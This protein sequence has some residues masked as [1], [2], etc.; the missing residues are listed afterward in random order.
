MRVRGLNVLVSLVTLMLTASEVSIELSPCEYLGIHVPVILR[1]LPLLAASV[2]FACSSFLG[3]PGRNGTSRTRALLGVV[4][5]LLTVISAIT[6]SSLTVAAYRS[7][8]IAVLR[9]RR[10]TLTMQQL[11]ATEEELGF[12]LMLQSADNHDLLLFERGTGRAAE[13][14]RKLG[15]LGIACV[16]A[17]DSLHEDDPL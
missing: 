1:L 5:S 11:R 9:L 12:T 6:I 10:G 2:V 15:L 13:L 8:T 3:R 17:T 4:V 14:A 7:R 16:G